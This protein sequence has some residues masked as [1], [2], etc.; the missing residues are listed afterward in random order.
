MSPI[1]LQAWSALSNLKISS[2]TYIRPGKTLPV[3]GETPKVSNEITKQSK[4]R[5]TSSPNMLP[6]SLDADK[7]VACR[8][9]GCGID[10]RCVSNQ[11]PA[12][13]SMVSEGGSYTHGR[14]AVEGPGARAPMQAY[15]VMPGN[16]SLNDVP[17]KT[18]S[19]VLDDDLDDDDILRVM[20]FN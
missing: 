15:G 14:R 19:E 18:S 1:V 2:R 8:T 12:S 6:A 11:F 16:C 10:K 17:M 7:H 5:S 9:I 4:L 13:N 3:Q 20:Y